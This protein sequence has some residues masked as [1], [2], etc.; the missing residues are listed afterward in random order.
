[1]VYVEYPELTEQERLDSLSPLNLDKASYSISHI[2]AG[3]AVDEKITSVTLS[4]VLDRPTY[5]LKTQSLNTGRMRTLQVFADSGETFGAMNKHFAERAAGIFAQNMRLVATPT[6][7]RLVDRDQWT[8][9]HTLNRHR[10]LYKVDLNDTEHT[11]LYVSSVTGQIV[12]D[13]SGWERAW[14]WLGSTVHWL[15]PLQLRKHSTFWYQLVVWISIAALITVAT[16]MIVGIIRARFKSRYKNGRITPYTGIQKLHHTLGLLFGI[17]V[18]MYVVSGLISMEPFGWFDN[19]S[20]AT[21]QIDRYIGRYQLQGFNDALSELKRTPSAMSGVKELRWQAIN[22]HGFLVAYSNAEN[23]RRIMSTNANSIAEQ[24]TS[25]LPKL[26]PNSS[27]T[28]E[29][30]EQHNNY[31]YSTHNRYR[32]LP[33]YQVKFSDEEKTWYYLDATTGEYR[34]RLTKVDRV[35]RWLYHGMH[36]LDFQSLINNQ[37]LRDVIIIFLSIIGAVFSYT[38]L[39]IAWRRLRKAMF[40]QPNRHSVRQLNSNTN[41]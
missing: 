29:R 32:P 10:P 31:Y 18:M 35:K 37:P 26:I 30:L 33:V 12:R 25:A 23:G 13:T 8:V 14:N 22:G 36:S 4:N 40:S 21:Q 17:I 19:K 24:V 39:S 11:V 38:S 20:S 16:G 5:H 1:M 15:Y 9:Y 34:M 3:L 6:F 7:T 28:I 27:Y 2:Q 41:L